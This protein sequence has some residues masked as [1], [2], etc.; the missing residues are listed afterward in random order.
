MDRVILVGDIVGRYG[1]ITSFMFLD[2]VFLFG[3]YSILN[4]GSLG[5]PGRIIYDVYVYI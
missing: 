2:L 3:I 5:A 4:I 1:K